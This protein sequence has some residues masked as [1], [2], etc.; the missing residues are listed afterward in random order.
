MMRRDGGVGKAPQLRPPCA[1]KDA[2]TA[3]VKQQQRLACISGAL[4][5]DCSAAQV[6]S[7]HKR[8]AGHARLVHVDVGHVHVVRKDVRV[9]GPPQHGP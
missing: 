8:A 4:Y 5:L 3:S 6:A 7:D 1:A 2:A 9:H